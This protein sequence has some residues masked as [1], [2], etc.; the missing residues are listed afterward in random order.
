MH[1]ISNYDVLP[2]DLLWSDTKSGLATF[3]TLI[4]FV[5]T[6]G[7]PPSACCRINTATVTF[8]SGETLSWFALIGHEVH[9]A[10]VFRSYILISRF[11]I[12]LSDSCFTVRFITMKLYVVVPSPDPPPFISADI[13]VRLNYQQQYFL[14]RIISGLNYTELIHLLRI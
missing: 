3:K 4:T 13:T 8:A 2:R 12:S 9:K 5:S 14:F 1:A 11:R 6:M 7:S 10:P